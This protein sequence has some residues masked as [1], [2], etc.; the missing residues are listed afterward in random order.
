MRLEVGGAPLLRSVR[1]KRDARETGRRGS[2]ERGEH[3]G[4]E[5]DVA[6]S[7]RVAPGRQRD[8]GTRSS[9]A[10]EASPRRRRARASSP[11]DR[12][13]PPRGR[14]SRSGAADGPGRGPRREAALA[15]HRPARHR[16]D[17]APSR[18]G[19]RRAPAI[20]RA[21]AD[22]R[23]G[24]RGSA[25]RSRA[26]S[27]TRARV[28]TTASP[29]A[30]GTRKSCGVVTGAV[31]LPVDVEPAREPVARIQR[32]RRDEGGRRVAALLQTRRERR[33]PVVQAEAGVVVDAV[34]G[35][36]QPREDARVRGEGHHCMGVREGEDAALGGQSV[37]VRRRCRA[38]CLRTRPRRRAGCRS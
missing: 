26:C 7:G 27:T 23:G 15:P 12:P 32:K 36:G 11:R 37:Q 38:R 31:H 22:R 24:P 6:R 10:R 29:A 30:S 5:V 3:G 34:L 18:I 16:P 8:P 2:A 20:R 13:A 9:A 35:R 33:V 4:D 17:R 14:R 28:F 19:S 1:K 25:A 21:R